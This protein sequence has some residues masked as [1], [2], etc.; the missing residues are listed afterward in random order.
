MKEVMK[1]DVIADLKLKLTQK[2]VLDVF[3]VKTDKLQHTVC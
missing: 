1:F 3:S 2:L